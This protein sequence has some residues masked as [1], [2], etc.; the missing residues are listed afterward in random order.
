M[1]DWEKW[2]FEPIDTYARTPENQRQIELCFA[3]FFGS[4]V[5]KAQEILQSTA[6]ERILH[7]AKNNGWTTHQIAK[8]IQNYVDYIDE[9]EEANAETA[10]EKTTTNGSGS[11]IP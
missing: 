2:G 7:V 5:P 4:T 9:K 3:I 6:G 10:N 8:E 11:L 1:K